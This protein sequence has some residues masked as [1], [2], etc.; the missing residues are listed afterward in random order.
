MTR[1]GALVVACCS[2]LYACGSLDASRYAPAPGQPVAKL[3]V[4]YLDKVDAR[5]QIRVISPS[6][7]RNC[8]I[9]VGDIAILTTLG[10]VA[11]SIS[12]YTP[13]WRREVQIAAGEPIVLDI[14]SDSVRVMTRT[15]CGFRIRFQPEADASYQMVFGTVPGSCTLDVGR[16]AALAD[17]SSRLVPVQFERLENVCK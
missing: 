13:E 17:G 16:R 3:D 4:Q 12:G 2:V 10:G 11:S 8:A 15:T 5:A 7:V 1:Y 6:A 9:G 14:L